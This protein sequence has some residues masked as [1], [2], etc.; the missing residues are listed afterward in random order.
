MSK[1]MFPVEVRFTASFKRKIKDLRKKYRNIKDDIE[2]IIKQLQ[3]GNLP[4]DEQANTGDLTV[5]K[6]RIR[7]SNNNKGSSF[8]YRVIYY[9]RTESEILLL[10]IYSKSDQESISKAKIIELIERENSSS[11]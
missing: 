2:P 4:G 3:E 1:M 5:F 11:G 6:V 7:N 10:T 8:G 9:I